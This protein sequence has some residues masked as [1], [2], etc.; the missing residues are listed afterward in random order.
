MGGL[1]VLKKRSDNA[2]CSDAIIKMLGIY[3]RPLLKVFIGSFL[4]LQIEKQGPGNVFTITGSSTL[5]YYAQAFG[6]HGVEFFPRFFQCSL[7]VV[8]SDG[9][10]I[11]AKWDRELFF[12]RH[13]C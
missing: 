8:L 11:P 12:T 4:N 1:Y 3:S 7:T 5:L 6:Q 10:D 2:V 13:S 9:D